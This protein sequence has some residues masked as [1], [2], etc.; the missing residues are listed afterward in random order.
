[1]KRPIIPLTESDNYLMGL[2]IR[3]NGQHIALDRLAIHQDALHT[4]TNLVGIVD[5]DLVGRAAETAGHLV[6]IL[7]PRI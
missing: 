2:A 1:M 4:A 3:E 7:M 5:D 6:A